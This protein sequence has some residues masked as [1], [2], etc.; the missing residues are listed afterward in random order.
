MKLNSKFNVLATLSSILVFVM[1][2]ASAKTSLSLCLCVGA[3]VV[4]IGYAIFENKTFYEEKN[5]YLDKLESRVALLNNQYETVKNSVD[6]LTMHSNEELDKVFEITDALENSSGMVIRNKEN[7]RQAADLTAEVIA[8][9]EEGNA[10]MEQMM[11]SIGE[12]KTLSDEIQKIIKVI[13]DIAFQ[14]NIL[15]LN[16]AVEAA[17]AGDAGKGFAV[18]ADEVRSLAQKSADAV[19]NTSIIIEKNIVSAENG[20]NISQKVETA[21]QKMSQEVRN[22]EELINEITASSEEQAQEVVRTKDLAKVLDGVVRS[23]SSSKDASNDE[24][25]RLSDKIEEVKD[26]VEVLRGQRE[27]ASLSIFN[28][29][30]PSFTESKKEKVDLKVTST[31]SVADSYNKEISRPEVRVV[32][33][34]PVSTLAPSKFTETSKASS[35]EIKKKE[36]ASVLPLDDKDLDNDDIFSD[37]KPEEVKDPGNSFNAKAFAEAKAGSSLQAQKARAAEI[38]PLDDGDGF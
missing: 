33:P 8:A 31:P 25:T 11:L 32:K 12:I 15:A 34:N 38:L 22:V 35:L 28:E 3:I 9:V 37:S 13:D 6:K 4:I 17:R 29:Y 16:A 30:E 26:I 19:K 5:E 36:A 1:Y 7:T 14:T 27:K 2:I 20:V 21:L 24:I 10:E 23:T 18:V